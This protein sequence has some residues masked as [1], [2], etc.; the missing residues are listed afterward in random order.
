MSTNPALSNANTLAVTASKSHVDK[1][2]TS[3]D[4][5]QTDIDNARLP[6]AVGPQVNTP[7]IVDLALLCATASVTS[8]GQVTDTII[9][10]DSIKAMKLLP[11]NSVDLVVTS[12]PYNLKNSTGDGMKAGNR[13]GKWANAAL[14][15]GY[16]SHEDNMAHDVYVKWQRQALT[17]MFRL[18]SDDGAIFYNHKWRVQG[19]LLQD[20]SDIVAGFPVRQVIIWKRSGGFNFNPGYFLPT[21]EVIYVIAKK[22]FKL[23]KGANAHGDVWEI[24]QER[25]NVH[26]A[27]FPEPL[28]RRIIESTNANVVLD[29]FNGSGTT[30]LV[31]KGLSR[32]F[33]GIELSRNYCDMALARVSGNADWNAEPCSKNP[34]VVTR[35]VAIST[36]IDNM[37]MA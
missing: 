7:R 16:D 6:S 12:P 3:N 33:I 10:G 35:K 34:K 24:P 29:P 9:C 8:I 13:N 20:R 15:K 27:P 26:P 4:S 1:S 5:Q 36:T 17:E 31:A 19:G 14:A 28:V 23:V 21:F 2:T 30:S 32:K 25:N 22:G 11:S 18:I 37:L